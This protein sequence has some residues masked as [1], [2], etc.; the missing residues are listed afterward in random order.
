MQAPLLVPAALR[1]GRPGR[2][3]GYRSID[4]VPITASKRL[5]NDVLKGEWGFTG[6]LVTDWDNV[7]RM[8]WEQKV[9]ADD[10]EAAARAIDAGND[11]VMTTPEFFEAAQTAVA[12][13][14]TDEKQI[15]EA[16]RRVLRLK[17]E[18]G[19]FENPRAP[20]VERQ[21]TPVTAPPWRPSR[22]TSAT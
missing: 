6:T 22:R 9:C 17:F 12:R 5:L 18:L 20:D 4:G 11:L 15:D 2:L 13:G 10:V 1:T 14:L 3:L 7:G 8:V 21:P 19:L 16:V